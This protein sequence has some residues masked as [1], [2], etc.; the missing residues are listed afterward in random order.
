MRHHAFGDGHHVVRLD[1]GED[2][3]G[4]LRR[5]VEEQ[6]IEAGTLTGLGSVDAI[7]LGCL[8][9]ATHEYLKRHF[10]ERMEVAA[11][12]GSISTDGE[13]PH[14]HLHM[15]V[16]PR[17]F[18]AYGGHVHDARVGAILE[19]YVTAFRGSLK[20]V[21]VEGQPF[22]HLLLPGEEAPP[23]PPA[24]PPAVAPPKAGGGRGRKD[25]RGR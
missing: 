25:A 14:L 13:R 24:S 10:E 18:I 23:P 2:V 17:E 3:L 12:S 8:D 7:T 16:S 1:P 22:P 15:V 9:P 6:G 21:L 4:V 20:R 5:V 19:V 11:L